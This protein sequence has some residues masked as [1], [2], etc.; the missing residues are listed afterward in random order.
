MVFPLWHTSIGERVM[1]LRATLAVLLTAS[2]FLLAGCEV[3]TSNTGITNNNCAGDN[4]S[5][6]DDHSTE[7]TTTTETTTGS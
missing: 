1:N 7:T 4:C 3:G 6:T 2:V 5:D